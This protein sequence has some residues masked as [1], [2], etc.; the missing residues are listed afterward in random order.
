MLS[1][2]DLQ[3]LHALVEQL[4]GGE[5]EEADFQFYDFLAQPHIL[6]VIYSQRFDYFFKIGSHVTPRLSSA[7]HVLDFGCGVGILTCLFAQQHPKIQFVGI[8]RSP[9]SINMARVEAKKRQLPKF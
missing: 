1:Q 5:N 9:R 4:Q 6:S 3:N 8:D 2:Q 7:E